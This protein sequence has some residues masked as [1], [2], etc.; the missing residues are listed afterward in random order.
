M[1]P[2]STM[3]RPKILFVDDEEGIRLTLPAI[4]EQSGFETA[5]AANVPD[6]IRLISSKKFDVLISDLNIETPGD[7]FTIVSAMRRM[8]PEATTFIL[9][10]YPAFETALEAI[11]QQVDDYVVKPADIPQLIE[12]ITAKLGKPRGPAQAHIKPRRLAELLGETKEQIIEEWFTRVNRDERMAAIR[13]NRSERIDHLGA[14]FDE[15]IE[16]SY[17][18]PSASSLH[19]AAQHGV[20]RLRQGYNI[21]MV[22]REARILQDVIGNFAQHNLLGINLSYIVPDLVRAGGTIEV[23]LEESIRSYV[24]EKEKANQETGSA[25]G[26]SVL[27]LSGDIDTA[28]LRAH[29]LAHAGFHVVRPNNRKEALAIL[30][31]RQF[32]AAVI[33]YTLSSDSVQEM[34]TLFRESNPQAP[35][36]VVTRGRLADWKTDLDVSVTAEEGP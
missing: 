34:T 12:R 23:F 24:Q 22:V 18:E 26:Y 36:V 15:L 20:V 33:S 30:K 10:G 5:I 1:K 31:K 29:A 32:D 13:L 7:G 35:I 25:E 27:L 11:R 21:P 17:G 4:L 6:A 3:A 8:Q 2:K 16:N 14:V 19:A 28:N 9:T